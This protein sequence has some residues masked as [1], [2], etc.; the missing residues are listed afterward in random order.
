[1]DG[2][3]RM[4]INVGREDSWLTDRGKVDVVKDGRVEEELGHS[5]HGAGQD[6]EIQA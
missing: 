3:T 6:E 2:G 1:M 4:G 5:G